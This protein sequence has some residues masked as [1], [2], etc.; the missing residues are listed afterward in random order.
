M[1]RGKSQPDRRRT[2]ARLSLLFWED[3]EKTGLE[4][5]KHSKGALL[6]HSGVWLEGYI[7][8]K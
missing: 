5:G 8:E 3:S 4:L 7:F 2:R 6:I 1:L